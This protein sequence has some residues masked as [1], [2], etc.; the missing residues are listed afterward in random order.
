MAGDKFSTPTTSSHRRTRSAVQ[1]IVL[2][3][4]ADSRR[5]T[6]ELMD[7][8]KVSKANR[9]VS[10]YMDYEEMVLPTLRRSPMEREGNDYGE[11]GE[12]GAKG[13]K[14]DKDKAFQERERESRTDEGAHGLEEG[15]H[16]AVQTKSASRQETQDEGID[17]LQFPPAAA[18]LQSDAQSDVQPDVAP[19]P[20]PTT[21]STVELA[22]ELL[23]ALRTLSDGKISDTTCRHIDEQR[24]LEI[25]SEIGVQAEGVKSYVQNSELQA[26]KRLDYIREMIDMVSA[27]RGGVRD[28]ICFY[29]QQRGLNVCLPY[30]TT[31]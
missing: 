1:P 3:D 6:D 17:Q 8:V 10:A 7:D 15:A 16:T 2:P 28:V 13:A 18:E 27:R 31:G 29:D 30:R 5:S 12:L 19:P 23:S 26:G 25:L 20:E 14:G 21:L 9:R 22:T 24:R 4:E 11:F